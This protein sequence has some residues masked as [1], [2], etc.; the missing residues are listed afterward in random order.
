[1]LIKKFNAV[2]YSMRICPGTYSKLV[3]ANALRAIIVFPIAYS[4]LQVYVKISSS[5]RKAKTVPIANE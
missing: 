3:V 5:S 2:S 4:W 1:M